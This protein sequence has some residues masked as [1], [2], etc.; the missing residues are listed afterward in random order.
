MITVQLC[1]FGIDML[2][3][4]LNDGHTLCEIVMLSDLT[5]QFF[6][7]GIRHS[8]GFFQTSL[9]L[10]VAADITDDYADECQTAGDD[11]Y[12]DVLHFSHT[13]SNFLQVAGPQI[14]SITRP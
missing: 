3:F 2:D 5:G 8:L 6:Q 7:F 13:P 1:D 4:V 11:R 10:A 12:N 14:P 9:H